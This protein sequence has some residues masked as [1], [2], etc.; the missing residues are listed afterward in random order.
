LQ[1]IISHL[2]VYFLFFNIEDNVAALQPGSPAAAPS[3][4]ARRV[5]CSMLFTVPYNGRLKTILFSGFK[6]LREKICETRK[7]E[8][9]HE[10]YFVE[11]NN[12]DRKPDQKKI[13]SEK[14]RVYAQ[15]LF[16]LTEPEPEPQ[17]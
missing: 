1:N 17:P 9:I 4:Q 2:K 15:K 8:S 7:L 10:K 12:E 11:R 13:E 14:T 3:H 16:A 5:F 6:I